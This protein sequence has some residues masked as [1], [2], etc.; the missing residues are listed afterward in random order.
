[1]QAYIVNIRHK[2]QAGTGDTHIYS[3]QDC[4]IRK[5]LNFTNTSFKAN[6]WLET[7]N[8]V[9]GKSFGKSFEKRRRLSIW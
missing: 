2:N 6:V 8:T 5:L 3:I 1:M 9:F 4:N 7:Q